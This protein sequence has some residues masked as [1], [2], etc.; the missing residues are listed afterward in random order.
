MRNL[1]G[2]VSAKHA[3]AVTAAVKTV[4]AHTDPDQVA[5]QW[6]AVSGSPKRP[7]APQLVPIPLAGFAL[8]GR[9]CKLHRKPKCR[10]CHH[11]QRGFR[12]TV[13]ACCQVHH[14][15]DDGLLIECCARHRMTRC[16]RCTTAARCCGK[17]HH[18]RR[19]SSAGS[20]SS[21][22]EESPVSALVGAKRHRMSPSARR[23]RSND[24]R[25]QQTPWASGPGR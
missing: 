8:G 1:H 20:A 22:S 3:P 24:G 2:A 10:A 14:G 13:E 17:G 15:P 25:S 19:T 4:F 5:A 18:D 12:L 9:L 6:D 21:S 16:G 7:D 23:T 11:M